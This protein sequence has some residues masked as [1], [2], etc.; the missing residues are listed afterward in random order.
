MRPSK[1]AKILEITSYPPPRA[2]WGVRVEFL[3]KRLEA[4]GH[5]CVV[6]N[7]G[8]SRF[9]PSAEYETVLSGSDYFKKVWRFSREGFV[10]HLHVNAESTKGFVLCLIAEFVNL[11]WGRRCFLTF[12]GGIGQV[13]F[14]RERYRWL[15]PMYWVLFGIPR[16]IIC[17]SDTVRARLAE[18]TMDP[19]KIVAIPAFSTQYVDRG[20]PHMPGDVERFYAR[21]SDV[22]F[23]YIR[24]RPGFY[25]DILLDG[26]AEVAATMPSAGL[27]ICGVS[28]DVDPL[29]LKDLHERI[30]AHALD[31]RVCI[32]EDLTHDEFLEALSR[33]ALYLRTPTTDGVAS[34]VLESLVLGVPVVGSENGSRPPGVITYR[35]TDAWDLARQV[36]RVI[37]SRE[38]IVATMKRPEPRDTLADEVALLT[39]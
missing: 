13:Y 2:G 12:H 19:G 7:I 18:Y 14:T 39:C 11:V 16:W 31:D 29:L 37:N 26:F 9:T 28:G 33:S 32:I 6:L 38:E 24:I 4:E 23:T 30:A 21:F 35:A 20:A 34:S 8:R 22:V 5:T 10:A 15:S 17:N 1:P 27:A 25:L 3:K 36:I